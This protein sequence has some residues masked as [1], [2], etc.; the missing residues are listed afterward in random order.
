MSDKTRVETDY[1]VIDRV[2][3]GEVDEFERLLEKYQN[4]VFALVSKHVPN[5]CVE[6]VAHEVFI[7]VFKSL[8]AFEARGSFKHWLSRIAVRSC[9]NFWRSHYKNREIPAS[10]ITEDHRSRFEEAL[11]VKA[12]EAFDDQ[13]RRQE[14]RELLALLLDRLS[15]SNRMVMTLVYFEGLTHKE[16]GDLLGWSVAKVKLRAYQSR[17]KLRK[18]VQNMLEKSEVKK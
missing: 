4:Y 13:V 1:E 14:D 6:E 7:Q 16:T 9:Y 11:S 17:K 18:I 12:G 2:K 3:A 15:A 5:D 8:P 10:S